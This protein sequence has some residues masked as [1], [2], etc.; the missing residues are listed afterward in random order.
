[1]FSA[2]AKSFQALFQ[3]RRAN[4]DAR[5]VDSY[6]DALSFIRDHPGHYLYGMRLKTEIAASA[7]GYEDMNLHFYPHDHVLTGHILLPKYSP[8]TRVLNAGIRELE[9]HSYIVSKKSYEKIKTTDDKG[10]V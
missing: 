4:P 2:E 10:P 7:A 8:F 3:D 5:I 6:S 1:M 9:L